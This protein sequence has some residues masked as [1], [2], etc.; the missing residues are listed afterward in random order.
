MRW[1]KE[2]HMTEFELKKALGQESELP[3]QVEEHLRKT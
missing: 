3:E 2:E 1:N